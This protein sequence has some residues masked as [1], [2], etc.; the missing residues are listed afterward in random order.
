VPGHGMKTPML[1]A[2]ELGELHVCQWLFENGAG[3]A[4]TE[5]NSLGYCPM[6]CAC[7]YGHLPVCK[8]LFKV[9][10]AADITKADNDGFTPMY[11]AC[12]WG[13]LS[14]CKWLL[15][16]G[17]AADIRTMDKYGRTPMSVAC[18]KGHLTVCKWLY[19]VGAA[20]DITKACRAG[21]GPL[22]VACWQGHLSVC[23]WLF[24]V[25]A[26]TDI[27]KPSNNG[28]TPLRITSREGHIPIQRWL[29][30]NGALTSDAATSRAIIRREIL[31]ADQRTAL[32][33]WAMD[34]VA[35]HKEFQRTFLVGTLSPQKS[36]H[37][38]KLSS[39]DDEANK[40]FKQL[41]A[42]FAGVPR[43][44]ELQNVGEAAEAVLA[45]MNEEEEEE[46]DDDSDEEEGEG[47]HLLSNRFNHQWIGDDD[48]EDDDSDEEEG[49]EI[50]LFD[51]PLSGH[52]DDIS[53]GT[54]VN[55]GSRILARDRPDYAR[56]EMAYLDF[57]DQRIDI[58]DLLENELEEAELYM[59][60]EATT[61]AATA[62]ADEDGDESGVDG[63]DIDLVISQASCTRAQAVIALRNN[64]G[65]IV[66]AIVEIQ[67]T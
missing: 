3:E 29:V 66:D 33:E 61:S 18:M 35:A 39:F 41:V 37:L 23:K 31:D 67:D 10:A 13:Y 40:H 16:V 26:A 4:I 53:I 38:W 11:S 59:H 34:R 62:A 42:D 30:V 60:A 45:V 1:W 49:E 27:S 15:E 64:D 55:R 5:V 6:Q 14:V 43:K 9:G 46:E 57:A 24:E 36:A 54:V 7:E 25:G 48:S 56:E 20:S 12:H 21:Q 2:V 65:D 63:N 22:F 51:S 52:Y 50:H 58:D 32:L 44:R 28:N 17:A 47:I 8:W 19:E